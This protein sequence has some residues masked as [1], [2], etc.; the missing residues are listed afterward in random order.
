MYKIILLMI[1]ILFFEIGVGVF[2]I[3][4]LK[5][6]EHVL[7]QKIRGNPSAKLKSPS[8]EKILSQVGFLSAKNGLSILSITPI[9]QHK[10]VKTNLRGTYVNFIRFIQD[11]FLNAYALSNITIYKLSDGELNI[12]LT[13]SATHSI[14][15]DSFNLK[16]LHDPFAGFLESYSNKSQI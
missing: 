3:Q 14:L 10:S 8:I 12:F 1:I 9:N 4:R 16:S 11:L 7:D 15:I 2:K 5:N 6:Q 13:V